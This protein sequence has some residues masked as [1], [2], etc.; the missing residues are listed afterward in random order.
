MEQNHHS[1]SHQHHHH[2]DH[3]HAHGMWDELIHHIPYAVFSVAFCLILLSFF[4]CSSIVP[5]A[6]TRA[7]CKQAH[8]LFH[9]FHFM[10]IVFAA[11]GTIIT[12]FRF[13]RSLVVGIL[14]GILSP[15]VFCTLSDS[16]LPYLG[17]RMLGVDMHF[18]LCF[19]K[20]FKTVSIFLIAG[21]INGFVMSKHHISRQGFYSV[22]SHF[23]HILISALAS[24]FFLISHGYVTWYKQIGPVFLFLIFAVVVPCTFADVV[25]PMTVARWSEPFCQMLANIKSRMAYWFS[26][27]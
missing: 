6:D 24:T 11:T 10:H 27:K 8:T 4:S 9:S 5:N 3:E 23:F 20:E 26:S 1:H 15:A 22:F 16:I 13:S 18:H 25:V 19:L 14:A 2:D 7:L 17:G 21:I 12:F